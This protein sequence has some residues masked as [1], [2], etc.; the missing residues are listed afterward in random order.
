[1]RAAA[2]IG[3][4]LA[5]VISGAAKAVD[6][7]GKDPRWNNRRRNKVSHGHG[8][9]TK[10]LLRKF[11]RNAIDRFGLAVVE[12]TKKGLVIRKEAVS[13]D[14]RRRLRNARKQERRAAR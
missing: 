11:R 7:G 8:Q 12:R 4:L 1:M 2:K 13:A 10:R 14:D 9:F 5:A 6:L 3:A